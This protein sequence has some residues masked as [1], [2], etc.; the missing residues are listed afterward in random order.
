M[1]IDWHESD[2]RLVS[3][4]WKR[5]GTGTSYVGPGDT[6]R[7]AYTAD[8]RCSWARDYRLYVESGPN[9]W[10][11]EYGSTTDTEPHIHVD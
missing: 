9:S 11:A 7:I 4:P 10:W 5:L 6:R 2:V 3:N 8:W 1:T